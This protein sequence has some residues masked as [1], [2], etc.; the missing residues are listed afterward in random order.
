MTR[1]DENSS[2]FVSNILNE[3]KEKTA[4]YRDRLS[5]IHQRL[6]RN[7]LFSFSTSTSSFSLSDERTRITPIE[8]LATGGLSAVKE[9]YTIFGLISRLEEDRYW[10]EDLSGKIALDLSYVIREKKFGA[11]LF[12]DGGLCFFLSNSNRELGCI[13]IAHGHCVNGDELSETMEGVVFQPIQIT[14]PPP[15]KKVRRMKI[16]KFAKAPC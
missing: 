16:S 2:K 5:L 13:I 7:P 1:S 15:E 8:A 4:L 9:A 3:A 14:M 11:G 6:E 10:I 12:T